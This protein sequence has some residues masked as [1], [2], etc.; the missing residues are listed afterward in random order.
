MKYIKLVKLIAI[1]TNFIGVLIVILAV[2]FKL[3][4]SNSESMLGLKAIMLMTLF[5]EVIY[6]VY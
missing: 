1:L 4:A 5:K 6:Y 3:P 2:C